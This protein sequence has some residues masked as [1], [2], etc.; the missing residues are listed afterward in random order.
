MEFTNLKDYA[1]DIRIDYL[2]KYGCLDWHWYDEGL[3]WA[4]QDYLSMKGEFSK[5]DV[6][7][8][9]EL[10]FVVEDFIWED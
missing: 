8:L 6:I 3:V 10:D 4:I 5:E 1:E 2:A 7:Y 9:K